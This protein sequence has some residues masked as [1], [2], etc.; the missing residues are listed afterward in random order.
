MLKK[1]QKVIKR[2]S[3]NYNSLFGAYLKKNPKKTSGK[4]NTFV[5]SEMEF[6]VDYNI[7]DYPW[8]SYVDTALFLEV[9]FSK[10]LT[11]P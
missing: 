4:K 8:P 1:P 10:G 7:D 3:E 5:T 6:N 11:V 2:V 9:Q